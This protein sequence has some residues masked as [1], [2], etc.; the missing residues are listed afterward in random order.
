MVVVVLKRG[1]AQLREA[2]HVVQAA[3]TEPI[4]TVRDQ[5]GDEQLDPR[6]EVGRD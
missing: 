1:K 4:Q 6:R 5:F 3:Q 2:W